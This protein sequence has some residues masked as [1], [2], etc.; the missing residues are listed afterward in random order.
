MLA[1]D[2]LKAFAKGDGDGLGD[3]L[4]R[5]RGKFSG[6]IVR[7]LVLDVHTHR[8]HL[9][10]DSRNH[11]TYVAVVHRADQP[12]EIWTVWRPVAPFG[13]GGASCSICGL[14]ASS[15]ARTWRTWLPRGAFQVQCHCRQLSI[16]PSAASVVRCHGPPST[17]TS[18]AEI[19]TF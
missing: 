14:P 15:I 12:T 8:G 4:A 10:T 18:T 7:L 17:R 6:E 9:S 11:S 13:A 1:P 3:V 19:P 16:E 2:P 5:E